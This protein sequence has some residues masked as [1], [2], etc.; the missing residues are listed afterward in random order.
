MILTLLIPAPAWARSL[1]PSPMVQTLTC[2]LSSFSSRSPLHPLNLRD[3]ARLLLSK[4]HLLAGDWPP[5][6][7]S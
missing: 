1:P 6:C 3:A 7:L 4:L 5:V 2:Q